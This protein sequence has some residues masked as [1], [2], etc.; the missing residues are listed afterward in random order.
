MAGI[1]VRVKERV[2]VLH[3]SSRGKEEDLLILMSPDDSLDQE[4]LPWLRPQFAEHA[5]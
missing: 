4:L 2:D 1:L 3:D 5:R